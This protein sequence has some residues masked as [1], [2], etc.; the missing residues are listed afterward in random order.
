MIDDVSQ[1]PTERNR[2][3][4]CRPIFAGFF[5]DDCRI[6]GGGVAMLKI[7]FKYKQK[8]PHKSIVKFASFFFRREKG[9]HFF[10][11]KCLGNVRNF[12]AFFF[13]KFSISKMKMGEKFLQK[14]SLKCNLF[15]FS[16]KFLP[17]PPLAFSKSFF[18]FS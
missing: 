17:I 12:Y 16:S 15:V 5:W 4:F 8:V 9:E 7:P 3:I 1:L 2:S 14:I 10:S 13:S 6:G 11:K 18:K